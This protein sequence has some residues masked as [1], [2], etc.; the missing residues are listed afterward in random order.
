MNINKFDPITLFLKNDLLCV[1]AFLDHDLRCPHT[2][3]DSATFLQDNKLTARL[4]RAI[5]THDVGNTL[6]Y[7][8]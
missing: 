4:L 6:F 2:W 1:A 8:T 5:N 7:Y 3:S